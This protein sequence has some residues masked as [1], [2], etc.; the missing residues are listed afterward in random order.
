MPPTTPLS[1][2][3]CLEMQA[4]KTDPFLP[5]GPVV[6]GISARRDLEGFLSVFVGGLNDHFG[7][8]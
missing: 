8:L 5:V 3:C 4:K 2:Q 6:A 1:H 7:Y